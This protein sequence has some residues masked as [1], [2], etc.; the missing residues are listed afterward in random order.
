MLLQPRNNCTDMPD[1][2]TE[3]VPLLLVGVVLLAFR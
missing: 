1:R 2:L 3:L